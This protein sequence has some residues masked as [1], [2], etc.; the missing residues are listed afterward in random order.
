[1]K[2]KKI[3]NVVHVT[4]QVLGARNLCTV[5][6]F[7]LQRNIV[8]YSVTCSKLATNLLG[9]WES[10]GTYTRVRSFINTPAEPPT[11]LNDDVHIAVDTS[12]VSAIS[13]KNS[14]G[15]QFRHWHLHNNVLPPNRT[16][17]PKWNCA[18]TR[19]VEEKDERR[20]GWGNEWGKPFRRE[21]SWQLLTIPAWL[22]GN[23]DRNS[24]IRA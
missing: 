18:E 24:W 6:P 23:D 14:W 4:E 5:S 15:F 11:I 22:H 17:N 19:G 2:E 7:A 12:S 8:Q 20:F 13:W 3:C 10:A 9:S 1:M 16:D 21:N